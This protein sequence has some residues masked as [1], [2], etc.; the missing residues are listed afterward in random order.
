MQRL[1]FQNDFTTLG[2]FFVEVTPSSGTIPWDI[3][4]LEVL[5][6][7]IWVSRRLTVIFPWIANSEQPP[8]Q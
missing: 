2:A 6:M 7:K 1:C 3:A 4:A 8:L 5:Q